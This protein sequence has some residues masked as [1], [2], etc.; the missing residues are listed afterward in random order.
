MIDNSRITLNVSIPLPDLWSAEKPFCYDCT[1]TVYD[2]SGAVLEVIPHIAGFRRFE[3]KNGVMTLNGKR[4]VF[5]GVNRHEFSCGTGRALSR[6]DMLWDIKN[7]KR[8]NINAV[9][10]SHYP[11]H[12]YFYEL[13]DKFGLYVMD[14]VNLETHGTIIGEVIPSEN[15]IPGSRE[16]WR[17][18]CLD[19][20]NSV[21]QTDKNHSCILIWS[22]GYES[23]G[24]YCRGR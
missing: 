20:A 11:N 10:T 18:A 24:G 13:C 23:G 4:I 8:N 1:F 7:L 22:C 17:D 3:I 2:G 6:E 14:E 15:T 12:P 9:R 19:R 5:K 16:E 21:F